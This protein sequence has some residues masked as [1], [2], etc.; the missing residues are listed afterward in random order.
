[1]RN[2]CTRGMCFV[3]LGGATAACGGATP[4]TVTLSPDQLADGWRVSTPA[5]EGMDPSTLAGA[6][7]VI[8][9]ER[10]LRTVLS[11]VVVRNGALVAEGYFGGTDHT[12]LNDLR[13]VTKSITSLLVG[14]AIDQRALPSVEA[15]FASYYPDEVAGNAKSWLRTV[16]LEDLL[17]MRSG[18][19]WDEHGNGDRDP[20]S[21]YHSLNSI[22]RVVQH[23]MQEVPGEVFRYSTGNSQL[24]AGM[25]TRATGQTVR[26]YAQQHLFAPLG[27]GPIRWDTHVDGTTYG[28]VRLFMRSRDMAKIGQLCLQ[29]GKWESQPL[30]PARWIRTS[31]QPHSQSPSGAYGYQWWIRP[32]GYTAQG[33]GGQYIYVFPAERVVVVLTADPNMGEHI[34][35]DRVEPLFTRHILRAI[36][37]ARPERDLTSP[38]PV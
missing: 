22:H 36:Q 14:V 1:M 13:S 15:T 23:G 35:F 27:I 5:A 4:T 29:Q 7:R 25:L 33:F 20:L 32:R 11:L 2:A 6:F 18:L 28:G 31:T 34:G 38:S 24:V 26:A 21:M 17:T 19:R 9:E 8:E 30:V 10:G 37:A 3:L 12:Y 16:T